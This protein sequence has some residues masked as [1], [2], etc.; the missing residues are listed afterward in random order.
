[1]KAQ[2]TRVR[3]KYHHQNEILITFEHYFKVDIFVA[4][5]DFQ[6]QELNG[7]FYDQRVELLIL[8]SS[9]C[10]HDSY[11]SFNVDDVY[12]LAKNF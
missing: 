7:S 5:I 1:M 11:N 10:S 12:N 2:Y 6:L 9:L 3:V 8:S 4:A